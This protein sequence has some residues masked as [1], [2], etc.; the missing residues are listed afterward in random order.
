M[1]IVT[2]CLQSVIDK[3][4]CLKKINR[5]IFNTCFQSCPP[6]ISKK[7]LKV[8]NKHS[9]YS[10]R[11]TSTELQ[12]GM[13]I[14][15]QAST[16]C[17]RQPTQAQLRRPYSGLRQSKLMRALHLSVHIRDDFYHWRYLNCLQKTPEA[18]PQKPVSQS[19]VG[20]G[21]PELLSPQ[22]CGTS[23]VAC[24]RVRS[25]AFPHLEHSTLP[26]EGVEGGCLVDAPLPTVHGR[27]GISISGCW[28][29]LW[30]SG[31][32][33]IS[34]CFKTRRQLA[35]PRV[36]HFTEVKFWPWSILIWVLQ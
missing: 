30:M 28:Q 11:A 31:R 19:L 33:S 12:L 3:S 26:E 32:P 18:L 14:Q 5:R 29:I 35:P 22:P 16:L 34:P 1:I 13:A 4:G 9:N 25:W 8:I 6:K 23:G 36:F 20:W 15:H 2:A 10:T 27:D 17:H 24:G 7:H 21:E